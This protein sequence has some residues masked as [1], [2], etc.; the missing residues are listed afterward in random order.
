L[1]V[2]KGLLKN[3]S[4]FSV[5]SAKFLYPTPKKRRKDAHETDLMPGD[6]VKAKI[7][8]ATGSVGIVVVERNGNYSDKEL[9][10][11]DESI[12]VG[13]AEKTDT[14]PVLQNVVDGL[15]GTS[16]RVRNTVRWFDSPEQLEVVEKAS[17]DK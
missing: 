11:D 17:R 3:K 14:H 1:T 16:S 2:I 9:S 4:H 7:G 6:V 10:S 12:A 8:P 5:T 15:T 13:F